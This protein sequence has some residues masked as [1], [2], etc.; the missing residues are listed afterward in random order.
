MIVPDRP[1]VLAAIAGLLAEH[2]INIRDI[3]SCTAV[4][5]RQE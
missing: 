5:G 2:R 3:G 1:G 4:G